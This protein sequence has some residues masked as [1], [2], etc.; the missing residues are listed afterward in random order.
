MQNVNDI[1]KTLNNMNGS[2][3][4][5]QSTSNNI[6]NIFNVNAPNLKK[7]LLQI[8]NGQLQQNQI[9]PNS[10]AFHSNLPSL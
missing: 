8:Q 4:N 10:K 9:C 5:N 7:A 2:N 1:V 6:Q 3:N